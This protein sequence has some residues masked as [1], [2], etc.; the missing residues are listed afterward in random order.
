MAKRSRA[1]DEALLVALSIF[2]LTT[3]ASILPQ[4]DFQEDP[5]EQNVERRPGLVLAFAITPGQVLTYL[6]ICQMWD[7]SLLHSA[8][9]KTKSRRTTS[10]LL[11]LPLRVPRLIGN[12]V[13]NQKCE[14]PFG[15]FGFWFLPPLS[16][17]N[18]KLELYQT[19]DPSRRVNQPL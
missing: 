7:A 16:A 10:G 13:R 14:A 4:L 6:R 18:P 17:D 8:Y 19:T 15:P 12:G 11:Q 1:I 5:F 9:P 2:E 3:S